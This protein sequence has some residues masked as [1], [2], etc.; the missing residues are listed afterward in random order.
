LVHIREKYV[1]HDIDPIS[2]ENYL[3]IFRDAFRMAL[4]NKRVD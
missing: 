1:V 4:G 2:T 3:E